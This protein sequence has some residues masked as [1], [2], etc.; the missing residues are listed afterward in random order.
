MA[1]CNISETCSCGATLTF[2]EIVPE[3]TW[4]HEH[5]CWEVQG[6]F[7][8]SHANCRPTQRP[9]ITKDKSNV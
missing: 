9:P 7:Q 3:D 4:H 8:K 1:R 6:K 5:R 2:S